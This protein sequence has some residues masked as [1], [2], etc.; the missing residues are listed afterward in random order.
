MKI[1]ENTS[2]KAGIQKTDDE[3]KEERV[4]FKINSKSH[5]LIFKNTLKQEGCSC[6]Y[7]AFTKLLLVLR[8]LLSAELLVRK[9]FICAF[10]FIF[11]AV[12][13]FFFNFDTK[14]F[15]KL[16]YKQIINQSLGKILKKLKKI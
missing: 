12:Y 6:E 4:S 8:S 11:L 1:S 10:N 9:I 15:Q 3:C 16:F 2:N 14:Q 5:Y 13:T 7:T